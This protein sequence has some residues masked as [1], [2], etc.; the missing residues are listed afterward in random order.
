MKNTVS[1]ILNLLPFAVSMSFITAC[2]GAY[3]TAAVRPEEFVAMAKVAECRDV[4]NLVYVIDGQFVFWNVAGNCPTMTPVYKL[5]GKTPS[6]LLCSQTKVPV[7]AVTVC[8]DG[9]ARS[10]FN[11]I[12]EHL[13]RSDLGLGATHQVQLIPF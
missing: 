9:S 12:V 3:E 5:F 7:G 4:H 10:M 6:D 13:D 8:N 1:S 2:G 11:T